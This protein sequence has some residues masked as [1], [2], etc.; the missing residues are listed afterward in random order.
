MKRPVHWLRWRGILLLAALTP[1]CRQIVRLA[2]LDG[3]RPLGR[4][5]RL[6][7]LLHLQICRGCE[8]YRRQMEFLRLAAAGS[9]GR[10][11]HPVRETL[12]PEAKNRIKRRLR[13]APTG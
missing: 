3:D 11:P 13:C 8:R 9:A 10:F 7:L 5:A 1:T 6:R 12:S 2:S 4:W